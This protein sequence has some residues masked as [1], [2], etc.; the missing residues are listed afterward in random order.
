M[1]RD[2]QPIY[3][4]S[5][6]NRLHLVLYVYVEIFDVMV[7][8]VFTGFTSKDLNLNTAR[9]AAEFSDV[10]HLHGVRRQGYSHTELTGG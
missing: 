9:I 6:I 3:T 4:K 10:A 8:F 2:L 5:F 1:S 7:F